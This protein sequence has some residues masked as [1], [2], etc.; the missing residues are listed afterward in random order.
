MIADPDALVFD[1][2]PLR[3]LAVQGWLG[4]LKFLAGDRPALIPES[5]E[6][7]LKRQAYDL[8][9][10]D[11]VLEAPW[12]VVDRSN[13][14]PFLAAFARYEKRLVVRGKN[15]GECGVLA[16]GDVRGFE[17]VLD[18]ATPRAIAEENGIR[19]TATLPLLCKAIREGQLTVPMVGSPG[20]VSPPGS[21]R[22]PHERLRSRGSS[23]PV[24]Q[25]LVIHCQC[26]NRVG[27]R[28]TIPF[29]HARAFLNDRSRRYLLRAQRR[30]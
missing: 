6:D 17:V 1:V 20:G 15:R 18:D 14:L 27:S 13:D 5:V 26:V 22:S 30:M 28:R 7:E 4:V 9:I 24:I 11:Q 8:P 29:H 12:I 2:G 3:H 23:H 16:L 10:L 21:H 25:R 19:T